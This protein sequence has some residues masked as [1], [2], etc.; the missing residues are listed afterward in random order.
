MEE[1]SAKNASDALV[2]E[3]F[4]TADRH[5]KVLALLVLRRLWSLARRRFGWVLWR[6][7][8]DA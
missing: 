2:R 3:R 7:L 5:E 4:H 1:R 6:S 8:N